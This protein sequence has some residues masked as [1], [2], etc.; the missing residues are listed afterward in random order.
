MPTNNLV[1]ELRLAADTLV[2]EASATTLSWL[3]YRAQPSRT[4]PATVL[5]RESDF[6]NGTLR[7]TFGNVVL[8]LVED[9][10]VE[11]GTAPN[12][13]PPADSTEY[14]SPPYQLGWFAAIAVEADDVVI[15]L[16]GF[17]MKQSQLFALQQRFYAIVEL[18]DQPFVENQGPSN[19]GPLKACS[20]VTIRN[21]TLGTSS[22]HGIHSPG[23]AS[24]ILIE[25]LQVE[26]FEV[27]GIHLNGVNDS[28][29]VSCAIG[30]TRR[31]VPVNGAYSQCRFIRDFVAKIPSTETLPFMDGPIAGAEVLADLDNVLQKTFENVKAGREPSSSAPECDFL[32]NSGMLPL[33]SAYGLVLNQ[34]GVA[35]NGFLAT[36]PTADAVAR[37]L[38]VENVSIA[39][40]ESQTLEVVGVSN[41]DK[42]IDDGSYG[43]G[44]AFLVG[45][46]GDVFRIDELT[47]PGIETR[48][49]DTSSRPVK[50]ITT[51]KHVGCYRGTA[52][53]T[54]Q[55][56]VSYCGK[57]V[58]TANIAKDGAIMA[59]ALS[60]S[61]NMGKTNIATV[62]TTPPQNN[63]Y[64][65]FNADSM[66][67][68][69]KG[70]IG[71]FLQG[72][73]DVKVTNADIDGVVQTSE[74]ALGTSSDFPP[75]KHTSHPTQTLP[76]FQG[77][78]ARGIVV[79]SCND[80]AF[81]EC[82]VT[83]LKSFHGAVAGVDLIGDTRNI[84]TMNL[85]V[86]RLTASM[87]PLQRPNPISACCPFMSRATVDRAS[88]DGSGKCPVRIFKA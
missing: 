31:N 88:I 76:W 52:L 7:V 25:D 70:N 40:I 73:E 56:F 65:I 27:A 81:E 13:F 67:H 4:S 33:G 26:D 2:R 63:M 62:L 51:T 42:Q 69:L 29:V 30:P 17:C 11:P 58:G 18:G 35:V 53:S 68:S 85:T 1:T 54:A 61:K 78:A 86:K 8:K 79:A 48:V 3:E 75:P 39:G 15:D 24:R 41:P 12:F 55:L 6:Q 38:V 77:A 43:G 44:G 10:V 23:G 83:G 80:V 5:L 46:V 34:R 60:G 59:W 21:G 47:C 82:S 16:N 50:I 74:K 36:A 49:V 9:V 64:R 22:H 45:P 87:H 14:P 32:L 20:R 71:L 66:A 19:F 84:S 72:V 28:C 57:D 37:N